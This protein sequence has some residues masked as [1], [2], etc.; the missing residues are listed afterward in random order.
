[1]LIEPKLYYYYY[2][3]YYYLYAFIFICLFIYLFIVY[4]TTVYQQNSRPLV[5]TSLNIF[6]F[7]FIILYLS[8][9][10]AQLL[11]LMVRFW[12]DSQFRNFVRARSVGSVSWPQ[13]VAVSRTE[14]ESVILNTCY[15]FCAGQHLGAG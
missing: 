12:A 14:G 9:L 10:F 8:S 5:R 11:V 4:L 1:M 6:C 13:C 15:L 3:Y 7:V 2:Y